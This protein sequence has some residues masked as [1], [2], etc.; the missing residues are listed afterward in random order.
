MSPLEEEVKVAKFR[1]GRHRLLVNLMYTTNWVTGVMQD[2]FKSY[3]I[4]NQQYNILRILRG[5]N[6]TP[7]TIQTLKDRMLDKQPDVSRL[8][9]RL[10]SKGLLG[11]TVNPD[12]RR[13]MNVVITEAGLDLLAEMDPAV[14][15][16]EELFSSLADNEVDSLNTLLDQVRDVASE[17]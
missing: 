3:G 13:K 6:P 11:R 8:V 14:N 10:Q 2:V 7:C 9:D 1:N 5:S 15:K 17:S 12:D 16:F 4:T